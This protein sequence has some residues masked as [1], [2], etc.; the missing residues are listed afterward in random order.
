MDQ[1][2]LFAAIAISIGVAWFIL[3]EA[4][5]SAF[6]SNLAE[7]GPAAVTNALAEEFLR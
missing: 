6:W 4:L 2:R 3:G 5:I 1:K 7:W